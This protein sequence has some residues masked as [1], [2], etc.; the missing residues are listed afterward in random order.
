MGS[1]NGKAEL[2][3]HGEMAAA[4]A[5]RGAVVAGVLV[6]GTGGA[7]VACSDEGAGGCFRAMASPAFFDGM[8]LPAQSHHAGGNDDCQEK[9]RNEFVEEGMRHRITGLLRKV[10]EGYPDRRIFVNHQNGAGRTIIPYLPW[11]AVWALCGT[12]RTG[13]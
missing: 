1:V 13:A 2:A 10:T 12:G 8:G 5:G 4:V 6:G 7:L 11:R 3:G 9:K